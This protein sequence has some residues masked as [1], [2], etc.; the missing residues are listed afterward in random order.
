MNRAVVANELVKVA[1]KLMAE[2]DFPPEWDTGYQAGGGLAAKMDWCI[3]DC[4]LAARYVAEGTVY[5]DLLTKFENWLKNEGVDLLKPKADDFCGD[6]V[7]IVNETR[8]L[9][10]KV[11]SRGRPEFLRFVT[12]G[13]MA[14]VL[15]EPN[16]HEL[17]G[18]VYERARKE[19]KGKTASKELVAGYPANYFNSSGA[20]S[21]ANQEGLMDV[22]ND[23][24]TAPGLIAK[25]EEWQKEEGEVEGYVYDETAKALRGLGLRMPPGIKRAASMSVA[26]VPTVKLLSTGVEVLAR[27][28]QGE[29]VAVTYGN[30]TQAKKKAESLGAGWAV[31]RGLGRPFYIMKQ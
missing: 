29:L 31:Y 26:A 5:R 23:D 2:Q 25:L 19:L 20:R 14:G 9:H 13:L 21:R 6:V 10:R 22:D 12:L 17:A 27:E 3:K 28:Y 16:V 7:F 4:V 15:E 24:L 1:K 18:L 11:L 8:K 30:R